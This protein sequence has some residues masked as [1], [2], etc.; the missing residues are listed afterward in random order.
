MKRMLPH[1]RNC[2]AD[3]ARHAGSS[4][5]RT[6]VVSSATLAILLVC[7]SIYQYSLLTPATG[8][9]VIPPRLPSPPAEPEG[10]REPASTQDA[11]VAIG[12]GTIGSGQHAHITLYNPKGERDARMEIEVRDWTPVAGS[13]NEFL[14]SEPDIRMRTNDG[15]PVRITAKRGVMEAQRQGD[16]GLDPKRGRLS[17]GVVI[18]YDRLS[19]EERE[20]LPLESRESL[21][22]ADIVR[23]ETDE[24][25]FDLEYAKLL[26][27]GKLSLAARDVT[28]EAADLE[29][30]FNEVANRVEYLRLGLGRLDLLQQTEAVG[31]KMPGLDD[32]GR[33]Q[34]LAQWLRESIQ[35]QWQTAE[36]RSTAEAG[37]PPAETQ[38]HGTPEQP[39]VTRTTDG[40]PVFRRENQQPSEPSTAIRYYARF[41]GDV[42]VDREVGGALQSRLT[43]DVLEIVRELSDADRK[44]ASRTASHPPGDAA[45]G[46]AASAGSDRIEVTWAQRLV[47]EACTP[48]INACATNAKSL[49][50]AEGRPVQLTHPDGEVLASQLI[51][52]PDESHF[53]LEGDEAAPARVRGEAEG[54]LTAL[55]IDSRRD[56]DRMELHAIGPGTSERIEK[57]SNDSAAKTAKAGTPDGSE[58][59]RVS[60]TDRMDAQGRI[61]NERGLDRTGAIYSRERRLLDRAVFTGGVSMTHEET[62]LSGD[63]VTVDFGVRRR[64]F[65][66]HQQII[67]RVTADGHVAMT[68]EKDRVTCRELQI[69]LQSY[70]GRT[71]PRQATALGE[72]LAQQDERLIRARDKLIVTFGPV[73]PKENDETGLPGTTS[74]IADTAVK[75]ALDKGVTAVHERTKSDIGVT[76]LQAYGDVTVHD[77][78]QELDLTAESLDC[79]LQEG[80]EIHQALVDG[81]PDRPASV[82]L[83]T[84]T[85]TGDR[86][87]LHA[88][89]ESAQV[90]GAGRLTLQSHKDLDGRKLDQPIP[91]SITW[92]TGMVYDGT[93]DRARFSGNVH[94]VSQSDTTFDCQELEVHFDDAPPRAAAEQPEDWLLH[95]VPQHLPGWTIIYGAFLVYEPI[96]HGV[97]QQL[98]GW[99]GRSNGES[100]SPTRFGKEP[101]YL[102]ATGNAV[103]LTT[104]L[105]P[106]TGQMVSRARIS[107]PKLWVNLRPEVS[108]MMIEGA[109]NLLLEDMEVAPPSQTT[110]RDRPRGLLTAEPSGPSTTLIEWRDLMWYDFSLEQTRFE[111]EVSLKHFSGGE[112]E[113]VL[114]RGAS[115]SSELDRG[116]ATFLTG[117]VL[118]V[119]FRDDAERIRRVEP[120][121]MGR[122][123][124]GRLEQFQASG[125]VRLQDVSEGLSLASDRVV[126]WKDRNLLAIYGSPRRKAHIVK[127]R[128]G[129]LPHQVSVEHLFYNLTTGEW[130]LSQP[131]ITTR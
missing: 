93:E 73:L 89:E 59:S 63:E 110:T 105:D 129:Q 77:P 70:E 74:P 94:A 108:K 66:E 4:L 100:S 124:A 130:E 123:S 49:I 122:L 26:A 55:V 60:F 44:P 47:V 102:V 120:R 90:P 97:I 119:D 104:E 86:I 78:S 98:A 85:I 101:S 83:D 25:E 50:S 116:R 33:R 88:K 56:G 54:S 53:R 57:N 69:E 43:A 81:M 64:G 34:T 45:G 17:G 68:R 12:Q 46:A 22:P 111:G 61:V 27:P 16:S 127:Q 31:L 48:A 112:L 20:A 42:S 14:L 37:P 87:L 67:E 3:G 38:S 126:F 15:H 79:T 58:V 35:N 1:V 72:I 92:S 8:E 7:F 30:R 9:R 5:V 11:G 51:F 91:I 96:L 65:F 80:H 75:T 52:E 13:G 82:R 41:E 29:L 121:R 36:G 71:A 84:F 62:S 39:A 28:L 131:R 99:T 106:D 40:T 24:L 115:E 21:D 18:Q 2:S 76:K 114:G 32:P 128:P 23:I 103:A 118:T 95:G 10:F 19:P 113:R 6:L 125:A 107:G 117:D 109:G